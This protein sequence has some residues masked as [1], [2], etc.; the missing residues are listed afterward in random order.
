MDQT[1]E[2]TARDEVYQLSLKVKLDD[3]GPQWLKVTAEPGRRPLSRE[4]QPHRPRERGPGPGPGAAHRRR[5][6][7]GVSLPAHLAW[8]ATRT[9]TSAASSSV[10]RGLR[11]RRGSAVDGPARA[12]DAGRPRRARPGWI[13]SSS[14]TWSRGSS[15]Q[16]RAHRAVRRRHG[17]DAGAR[18]RQAGDAAGLH[19]AGTIRF[20]S[21]CPSGEPKVLDELDGFPLALTPEG[22]GAGSSTGDTSRR[23]PRIVGPVPAALLG[24]RRRGEGRGRGAGRRPRPTAATGRGHRPA[25]LRLRPGAVRRPRLHSGAGGSRSATVPPSVLGPGGTVGGV[26]PALAAGERGRHDS[27]SAPGD[28]LLLRRRIGGPGRGVR[29]PGD[30]GGA[31]ALAA[32][33][34]GAKVIRL[35]D[36]PEG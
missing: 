24:G 23:Q 34:K 10:S 20:A 26:G 12:G 28:V 30:G 25:E 21:C 8:A 4:Q 35:P 32:G 33:T 11:G 16:A 29:R 5:R 31:D 9:W 36:G 2:H 17:G 15:R 27:L 22:S 6:P 18:R 13:A 1:I 3:P 7:V 19:R 14:A